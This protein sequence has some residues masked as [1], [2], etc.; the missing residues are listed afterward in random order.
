MLENITI[1]NKI[2]KRNLLVLFSVY[3]NYLL[4]IFKFLDIGKKIKIT[5]VKKCTDKQI[6]KYRR[7]KQLVNVTAMT[8]VKVF[9]I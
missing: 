3:F 6:Q 1:H 8:K 9:D 7:G 4:L 2:I 5:D